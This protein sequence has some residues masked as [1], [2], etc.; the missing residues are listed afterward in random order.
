M[1]SALAITTIGDEVVGLS[2]HPGSARLRSLPTRV[3][4]PRHARLRDVA[5]AVVHASC[6]LGTTN[7]GS[8]P[9]DPSSHSGSKSN[10]RER[11]H[12]RSVPLQGVTWMHSRANAP[13]AAT[14]TT[15]GG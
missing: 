15:A 11:P 8:R 7:R 10:S 3:G 12:A 13:F 6:A 2:S 4:Y 5:V 9:T 1:G 14:M